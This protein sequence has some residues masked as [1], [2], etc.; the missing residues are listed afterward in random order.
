[1]N[2][3][4]GSDYAP[5]LKRNYRSNGCLFFSVCTSF[6]KRATN[7][8]AGSWSGQFQATALNIFEL[9]CTNK[10]RKHDKAA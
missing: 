9:G 2:V 7:L 1:M 3:D 4:Q 5:E 8:K 10:I 6:L